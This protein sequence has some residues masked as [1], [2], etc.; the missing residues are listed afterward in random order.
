[1]FGQTGKDSLAA[2]A[3]RA[4]SKGPESSAVSIASSDR[5]ADDLSKASDGALDWRKSRHNSEDARSDTSSTHRNRM[6][7]LFKGRKKSRGAISQDELSLFDSNEA[8]P[9]VPAIRPSTGQARNGSVDSLPLA[10]SVAS[11]LLTEDSDTE[12]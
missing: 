2:P 3:G 5:S 10:K 4:R 7:K 1:M 9:P 11:S 6:S 12:S 8:L